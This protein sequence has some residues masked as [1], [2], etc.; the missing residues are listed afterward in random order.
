MNDDEAYSLPFSQ[1]AF[2]PLVEETKRTDD[3]QPPS[4]SPN[5]Q[6]KRKNK[7]AAQMSQSGE[8]PEPVVV[9]FEDV[10]AAAFRIKNGTRCTPCTVSV[11]STL[12]YVLC[13]TFP[14]YYV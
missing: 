8:T 9:S 1:T 7:K 5:T 10:T 12:I 3:T 2:V 13:A 14:L 4:T 11:I 6:L